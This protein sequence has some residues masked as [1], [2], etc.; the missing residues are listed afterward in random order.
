LFD[1]N[2]IL[3]PDKFPTFEAVPELN[4]KVI[5]SIVER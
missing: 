5:L 1:D 4:G 3:V 2:E